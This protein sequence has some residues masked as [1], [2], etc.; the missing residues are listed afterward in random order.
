MERDV[1]IKILDLD[2]NRDQASIESG[3]HQFLSEFKALKILKH[4][5][6]IQC[7]GICLSPI[8]IIIECAPLLDLKHLL[9]KN[10]PID[11]TIKHNICFDIATGMNY[12]HQN[13]IIHW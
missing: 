3:I 8:A 6:I 11:T 13:R 1:A 4:K 9:T 5:N 7:F 2:K 10:S 12:I